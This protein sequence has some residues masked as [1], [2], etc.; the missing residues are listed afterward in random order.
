LNGTVAAQGQE[1]VPGI[2]SNPRRLTTDPC[3]KVMDDSNP[4]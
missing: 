1:R 2:P 3:N 4:G